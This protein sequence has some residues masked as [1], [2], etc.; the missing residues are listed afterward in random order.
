MFENP[1]LCERNVSH[2]F[3]FE[4]ILRGAHSE[5]SERVETGSVS[6]RRI[7]SDTN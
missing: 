4:G 5:G 3:K 2:L 1:A 6:G 7:D